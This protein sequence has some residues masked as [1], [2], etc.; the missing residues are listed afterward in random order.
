MKIKIKDNAKLSFTILYT[1]TGLIIFFFIL[2]GHYFDLSVSNQ[3]EN[4]IGSELR[5]ISMAP[6]ITEILY[7]LGLSKSIVGITDFCKYPPQTKLKESIGGIINPD[8]EKIVSLNPNLIVALDSN[9]PVLSKIKSRLNVRILSIKDNTVEEIIRAIT[10]IGYAVK[11]HAR[12]VSIA[13]KLRQF[14][15]RV[16]SLKSL[17]KQKEVLIIVGRDSESLTNLFVAGGENFIDELVTLA[18]GRNVFSN[19]SEKYLPVSL[20]ETIIPQKPEVIIEITGGIPLTEEQERKYNVL[21]N[22]HQLIPA[23]KNK[24]IYYLTQDYFVIPGPR[25]NNALKT[26]LEILQPELDLDRFR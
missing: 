2:Q 10:I 12:A 7:K 14:I 24:K 25:I 17:L 5:I 19:S 9:K 26:Y 23:V 1:L 4:H 22:E 6:N 21:W 16:K 18:G 11:K 15:D 13:N 20:G 3:K 8:I